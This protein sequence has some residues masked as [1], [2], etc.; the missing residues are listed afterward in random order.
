MAVDV[1]L[2]LLDG[3]GDVDGDPLD[4]GDDAVGQVEDLAGGRAHAW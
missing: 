4:V 1:A 3:E 2:P